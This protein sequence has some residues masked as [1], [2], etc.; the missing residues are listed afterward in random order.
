M[1]I[2]KT[3]ALLAAFAVTA[4]GSLTALFLLQGKNDGRTQPA[5][6]P[7]ASDIAEI[8]EQTEA[9]TTGWADPWEPLELTEETEPEPFFPTRMLDTDHYPFFT[10]AGLDALVTDNPLTPERGR[11]VMLRNS[12]SVILSDPVIVR[13]LPPDADTVTFWVAYDAEQLGGLL[14]H[15]M[16]MRFDPDDE[17]GEQFYPMENTVRD[18][19]QNRLTAEITQPGIYFAFNADAWARL[20]GVQTDSAMCYRN[21][22]IGFTVELP[23]AV[24]FYQY[25]LD[26][27]RLEDYTYFPP[28]ERFTD[29]Y[30]ADHIVPLMFD[31]SGSAEGVT[32]FTLE[33]IRAC[34]GADTAAEHRLAGI[35]ALNRLEA[36]G[37]FTVTENKTASVGGANCRIIA[38]KTDGDRK[39]G[40]SG[41]VQLDAYYDLREG[42]I[43]H[44]SYSIDPAKQ[45]S[46][47]Q[48][49][50]DSLDTFKKQ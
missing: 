46:L 14:S 5:N 50:R 49:L 48:P 43:V 8:T 32:G 40:I 31:K 12:E 29:E 37:Q 38:A 15:A 2:R 13:E 21:P 47:Y 28:E 7:G 16:L 11:H 23:A 18:E 20:W 44:I 25:E 17:S 27:S 42:E 4:V 24:M 1:Q 22:D 3:G 26:C 41:S 36:V 39:Q 34:D 10:E 33:W 45:D 19:Q 35:E 6:A 30:G 9:A